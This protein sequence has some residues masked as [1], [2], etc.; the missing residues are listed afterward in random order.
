MRLSDAGVPSGGSSIPLHEHGVLLA[1]SPG[2]GGS[3]CAQPSAHGGVHRTGSCSDRSTCSMCGAHCT[4]LCCNRVACARCGVDHTGSLS[5]RN[6]CAVVAYIVPGLT[7]F[8]ARAPVVEFITP[9]PAVIV[10]HAPWWSPSH[11]LLQWQH[12]PQRWSTSYCLL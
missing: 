8:A 7:M 12:L 2:R 5:A 11:Q 9:D 10:A 3:Q 4:S 1:S 6:T